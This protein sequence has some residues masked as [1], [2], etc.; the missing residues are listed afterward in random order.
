MTN[1]VE[2]IVFFR[3]VNGVF[4][5]CKSSMC[6]TVMLHLFSRYCK[7]ILLY[8]VQSVCLSNKN[9]SSLFHSWDGIFVENVCCK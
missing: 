2:Y 4:H 5:K 6:E 8:A 1:K 7:P 9:L 3:S